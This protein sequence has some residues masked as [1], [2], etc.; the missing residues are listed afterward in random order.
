MAWLEEIVATFLRIS[1]MLSGLCLLGGCAAVPARVATYSPPLAPQGIV[2][3]LDGAGGNAHAAEAVALVVKETGAPLFVR[4]IPWSHGQKRG[5][6]DMT[7]VDYSRAQ[8][9]SLAATIVAY[10]AAYPNLP[11]YIVAHSAGAFVAL[12]ATRWLE[13]NSL[14]R[15]VLLAPAVAADYDLRPALAAA[16]QGVDAFTSERDR[17]YLGLGTAL[18]GTADGKRFTPPAG[19]VGFEVPPLSAPEIELMQRLRQHPWQPSVAWTGNGGEHAG[20]L[21]LAFVRAYVLP[22]LI[23]QPAARAKA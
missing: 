20:A 23:P 2:L 19:R 16:R 11:I 6:A 9:R 14:E 21:R 4:S 5:L 22:L 18:V 1:T 10:R 12:E 8:G 7:D 3:V 13:P 15:I 17:F